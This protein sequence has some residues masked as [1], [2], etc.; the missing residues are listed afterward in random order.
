MVEDNREIEV[1]HA[2]AVP[3]QHGQ[4]QSHTDYMSKLIQQ[5]ELKDLEIRN[6]KSQLSTST[7]RLYKLEIEN[8]QQ[9]SVMSGVLEGTSG[10]KKAVIQSF[11]PIY[12]AEGTIEK[13][14]KHFGNDTTLEK[15]WPFII[16]A[17]IALVFVAYLWKNPQVIAGFQQNINNPI[18][19]AGLVVFG[20]AVVFIVLRLRKR[21]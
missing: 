13:A 12:Q 6:L 8:G 7:K 18:V 5:N 1:V 16:G 20:I 14:L 9:R 10:M 15:L 3:I 11:L 2:K 19:I 4:G 17:I 21:K